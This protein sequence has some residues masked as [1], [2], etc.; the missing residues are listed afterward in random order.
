MGIFALNL[1][2]KIFSIVLNQEDFGLSSIAV[3]LFK[4]R[5]LYVAMESFHNENMKYTLLATIGSGNEMKLAAGKTV[6]LLWWQGIR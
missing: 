3:S 6:I 4:Y 2:E 1:N 5:Y